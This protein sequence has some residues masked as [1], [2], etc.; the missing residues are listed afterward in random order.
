MR[1]HS[2]KASP[3]FKTRIIM[4]IDLY[5]ERAPFDTQMLR[6]SDE[7]T[8]YVEQSGNPEGVPVVCF[9][10][11]PGGQ[12]VPLYRR[13]FDPDHYRI[14]LFDQRGAG[15]STPHASLDNNTTFD[16]IKDAEK[17]RKALNIE[18]WHCFGGSW[19]ST[20]A[21]IY[22]IEHP[23]RVLSICLRGVFLAT[24]A[25]VHWLYQHGAS[26]IFPDAFEDFEQ[27]IP[28]AER[29]DLLRAYHARLTSNDHEQRVRF[30]HHFALWESSC[31]RLHYVGKEK[32]QNSID[33]RFAL[34]IARLEAHYFVNASFL[35]EDDWILSR[36]HRLSKIPM[37]IVQ[38]RYD[39]VC[40]PTTAWSLKKALPHAALKIISDAGHASSEP[41]IRKA[42]VEA[43]N[44][45]KEIDS[46]GA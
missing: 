35:D 40:P 1:S 45:F 31:S 20:M 11:G 5:A 34:Q 23:E 19:G 8:I 32:L 36:A 7:H 43:M 6:V 14:I 13:F 17:I 4:T 21:L 9:H 10:G 42:L 33:D 12:S 3:N 30:A 46:R 29:G 39:V 25:E 18:R 41:G 22:G 44:T 28:Q 2:A 24:Q 26:Q 16:L 38:G 27:A 15:R 37:T